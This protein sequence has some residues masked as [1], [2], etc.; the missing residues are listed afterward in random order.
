MK[1]YK[2][3]L[4]ETSSNYGS[5]FNIYTYNGFYKK[6]LNCSSEAFFEMF[7]K[8]SSSEQKIL[9]SYFAENDEKI[10]DKAY[11]I[12]QKMFN[13][14]QFTLKDKYG[15]IDIIFELITDE[16]DN[17]YGKEILTGCIFP[18]VT[19][20]YK[21]IHEKKPV[22]WPLGEID[23]STRNAYRKKNEKENIYVDSKMNEYEVH[24]TC[25][26]Y[27]KKSV[28]VG[29]LTSLTG[30]KN[31]ISFDYTF[32]HNNIERADI[33]LEKLDFANDIEVSNYKEEHETKKN[34]FGKNK[35]N[36][37][38]ENVKSK[39]KQN[40]FKHEIILKKEET[41]KH[42]NLNPLTKLMVEIDYLLIKLKNHSEELYL[43][44]SKLYNELLQSDNTLRL[45]SLS[46]STL[47]MLK[48]NILLSFNYSKKNGM[49]MTDYLNNMINVY[50]ENMI[51]KEEN[52]TRLTI[53]ELDKITC[54]YL[55]IQNEYDIITQRKIIR[56]ISL[57]YLLELCE[58]KEDLASLNLKNSYVND[59]LEV[60]LVCLNTLKEQEIINGNIYIELSDK[61]S[62]DN[63]LHIIENIK[64]ID[65]DRAK[66]KK[67]VL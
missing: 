34:I 42:D 61:I 49:N 26:L 18:I 15:G 65:F 36:Y 20:F 5:S 6:I 54:L 27:D 25:G 7:L 35:F 21:I 33:F 66:V 48:A 17:L 51:N 29:T 62:L 55:K 32:T 8:L 13:V 22:E 31:V 9:D 39:E 63:L 59:Y 11:Q 41:I 40:V 43:K 52:K 23:I 24:G 38:L 60:I 58:N 4:F 16:E 14:Y 28:R 50:F 67:I 3:K 47:E 10:K 46:K 64:F 53:S 57:L 30:H 19:K 44:Y 45:T 2:G 37:F 12:L 56:S 1:Y